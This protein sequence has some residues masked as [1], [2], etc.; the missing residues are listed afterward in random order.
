MNCKSWVPQ[1]FC[2]K[3]KDF[4]GYGIFSSKTVKPGWTWAGHSLLYY[5]FYYNESQMVGK[6]FHFNT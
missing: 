5:E 4:T 1:F 2:I 3:G 6:L